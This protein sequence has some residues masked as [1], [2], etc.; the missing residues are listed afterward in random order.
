MNYQS[1][2]QGIANSLPLFEPDLYMEDRPSRFDISLLIETSLTVIV[3]ISA[4]KVIGTNSALGASWLITPGILIFAA[5]IPTAVKKREFPGFGFNIR[6][7]KDSLVVLGW[8]CAVLF[9]LTLCGLWGLKSYELKPPLLP[10]LSQGQG[11]VYWI[12]Y[13]FMYVALS[14]EVFFRGYVQSN[15]LRLT[16]P[17][18]G[19][20]PR[21]QQWTSIVISATCFTVAHIIT[22]GQIISVLIFLPG[23]VL[24]GL[25]I[26]TR[27]LLAPILFHG[28]ANACYLVMAVVLT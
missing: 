12:F 19:K 16:T 2:H 13:Q 24:G 26:R 11:W 4:I 3:V 22:K 20:L 9:P 8:I 25:F 17:V 6:Q 10:V 23:L 5:F 28:L 18:M 27:S 15:I 14:E 7:I 1:I 21:L